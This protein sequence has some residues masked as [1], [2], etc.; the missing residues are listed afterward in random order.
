M[1]VAVIYYSFEGNTKKVAE[2]I[3]N[4]FNADIYELREV[5]SKI[6]KNGFLKYFWGGK[7]VVTKDKPDLE[8]LNIDLNNY[9]IL[10]IG[11]PVWAFTYSPAIRSFFSK[12]VIRNKKIGLFCCHS[13]GIKNTIEDMKKS[14][15]EN[16]FITEMDFIDPLKDE[17]KANI[18]IDNWLDTIVLK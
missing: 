17:V 12:Y 9:D 18:K 2:R 11:T 15:D 1:K 6:P 13:G 10:F 14:L 7:Q 4:K 3:A 16:E 5:D 8:E